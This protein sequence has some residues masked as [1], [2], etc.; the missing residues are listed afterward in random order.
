MKKAILAVA[1]IIVAALLVV[2]LAFPGVVLKAAMS[3]ERS[4]AG[5]EEKSVTVGDHTMVYLEGGEGPHVLLIHGFGA[6][7]DNWTR[8]ARFLTDH[9]HVV[10]PDL[11]GFGESS[12]ISTANYGILP[13]ADRLKLFA[14]MVNLD[15]F[16]LAGNSMGGAIVGRFAVKYPDRVITLGLIDAAGVQSPEPSELQTILAKG[17]PNPLIVDSP[18]DYQNLM[19]FVFVKPPYI[20]GPVLNYFAEQAV[21]HRETNQKVWDDLSAE[22]SMLQPDL[23]LI[24][25]P[26]LILWGDQD[27]LI[28]VSAVDVFKAGI[29]NSTAVIMKDC[30]HAP[31]VERPRE[32]AEHFLKFIGQGGER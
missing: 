19:K 1:A 2:Y 8:F 6:D 25:A 22:R 3:F 5:L 26:T 16:H 21:T 10:A 17:E 15:T 31:M 14:D 9:Y 23:G 27:R 13:Q 28:H 12:K 24:K 18:E 20:P 32:S 4:R 7:K 30:G 29:S 11:P